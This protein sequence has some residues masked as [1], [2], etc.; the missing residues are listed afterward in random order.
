MQPTK[1]FVGFVER[2]D[3]RCSVLLFSLKLDSP[4][5]DASGAEIVEYLRAKSVDELATLGED[6]SVVVDGMVFPQCGPEVTFR[7]GQE[8]PV[9]LMIGCNSHEGQ[10][11]FKVSHT[12]NGILRYLRLDFKSNDWLR[13]TEF[14]TFS[15]QFSLSSRRGR[16][17]ELSFMQG[18]RWERRL[19]LVAGK[20]VW[21][22]MIREF[23]WW[24][25][26]ETALWTAFSH[27]H[28]IVPIMTF[29]YYNNS[30]I[31]RPNIKISQRH[32]G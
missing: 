28:D 9:D 4:P 2:S 8:N 1:Q 10:F 19:C 13:S 14:T 15:G 27:S 24:L 5:P 25:Y 21:S 29:Y 16:Q 26:D 20:A 7:Q 31:R 11:L 3:L 12:A 18:L 30:F 23:S 22:N 6:F 17:F 32:A